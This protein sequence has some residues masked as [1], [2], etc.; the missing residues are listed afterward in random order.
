MLAEIFLSRKMQKY[1]LMVGYMYEL[2]MHVFIP[3]MYTCQCNY[4]RALL[5]IRISGKRSRKKALSDDQIG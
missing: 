3:V 5:P 4:N 1:L 2:L